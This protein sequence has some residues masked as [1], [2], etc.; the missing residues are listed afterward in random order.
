MSAQGGVVLDA[1][2][3]LSWILNDADPH[4]VKKI[5]ELLTNGFAL[6][7]ELWHAEVA[8]GLRN[9]VRRGLLRAEVIDLD[10]TSYDSTYRL[11]ACAGLAGFGDSRIRAVP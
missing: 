3:A 8:N 6:V 10:L 11:L 2:A 5:D 7:P 9:A 4:W 1:S